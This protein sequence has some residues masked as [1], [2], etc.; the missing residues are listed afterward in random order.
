VYSFYLFSLYV[1]T[2]CIGFGAFLCISKALVI[3]AHKQK[4]K[5]IAK[6]T[7]ICAFAYLQPLPIP[8][9]F[10]NLNQGRPRCPKHKVNR[11]AAA[12]PK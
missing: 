3:T 12:K 11:N 6:A 10:P 9:I 7:A 5:S 8:Q 2:T 4:P 1:F